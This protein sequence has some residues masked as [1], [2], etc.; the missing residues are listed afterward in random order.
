VAPLLCGAGRPLIALE[1]FGAGSCRLVT[2]D[3]VL[4]GVDVRIRLGRPG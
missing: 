3:A 4:T 2:R 1:A